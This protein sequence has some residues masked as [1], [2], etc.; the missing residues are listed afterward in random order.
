[1]ARTKEFDEQEVL[2][3]AMEVF[4]ARGYHGTSAQDL[5]DEL[6]INRSSLYDTFGDKRNLFIRVLEQYHLLYSTKMIEALNTTEDIVETVHIIL[7]QTVKESIADAE[8]KGCFMVNSAVE[9]TQLDEDI[10]Q[11]ID[12]NKQEVEDALCK[13]LRK[14]Q[15]NGQVNKKHSARALSRTIFNTI[16]GIRVAARMGTPKRAMEDIVQVTVTTLA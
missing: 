8:V 5:V 4:W 13:A 10:K 3:K 7:R 1:M 2:C 14:G 15:E 6:G 16:T 11:I 12:K 9:F